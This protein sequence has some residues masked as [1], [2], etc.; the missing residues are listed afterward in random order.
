MKRK[1]NI[2][3]QFKTDAKKLNKGELADTRAVILKLQNDEPL[4]EKHHDHDLH[5]NYDG[6]RECH[7]RPD[8]LLVYKKTAEGKIDILYL[9]RI[10]SHT[11]IFDISKKK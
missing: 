2:A 11:N 4:E 3:R 7:I 10:S 1:L 8:L 9:A 6:Y 5:G